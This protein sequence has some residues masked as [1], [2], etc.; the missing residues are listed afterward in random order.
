MR[1]L[2][3]TLERLLGEVPERFLSDLVA[4]KLAANDVQLSARQREGRAKRLE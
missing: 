3:E 2:Q 4:K 1:G